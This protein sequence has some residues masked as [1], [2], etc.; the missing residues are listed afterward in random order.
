MKTLLKLSVLTAVVFIAVTTTTFAATTVRV[1]EPSPNDACKK[2]RTCS[3]VCEYTCTDSLTTDKCAAFKEV[4]R[5]GTGSVTGTIVKDGDVYTCKVTVKRGTLLQCPNLPPRM[6]P[7]ISLNDGATSTTSAA[8]ST[9]ATTT[10]PALEALQ[11]KL[12]L[13]LYV[14]S[15]FSSLPTSYTAS[16]S[17]LQAIN[18]IMGL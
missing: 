18:M 3:G 11:Q 17:F 10:R 5:V 14:Q 4:C 9:G 13:L 15:V 16:P 7:V 2:T 1:G 6:G 8:P 12:N